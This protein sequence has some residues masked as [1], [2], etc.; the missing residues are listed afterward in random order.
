MKPIRVDPLTGVLSYL[1]SLTSGNP[2]PD[3][4]IT[5]NVSDSITVDT[6]LP[7]DTMIWETGIKR[8]NIEGKWVIVEQYEDRGHAEKG[9]QTWVKLMTKKPDYP[10]KDIDMWGGK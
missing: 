5:D 9:H 8:L 4:Q 2:Y 3:E 1:K 10:L 7:K 6:S